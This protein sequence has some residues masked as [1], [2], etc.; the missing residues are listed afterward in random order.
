MANK[1]GS[2]MESN[3]KIALIKAIE[4]EREGKRFYLESAQKAVSLL[5]RR[6]FEELASAEDLHIETIQKICNGLQEDKLF[7]QWVTAVNPSGKLEKVFE[8][9]LVEKA[10]A[11][12]DDIKALHF[13][14]E[15]EEKS[16]R[17]Y[18]SLAGDAESPFE[19]RFYLA[20]SYEE[21]GHSLKIMDSIEYLN[22]PTSW[23][24]LRDG[25]NL[26]G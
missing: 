22:D 23:I 20:L 13:G 15:L 14:L 6:V 7:R 19:R 8:E 5:A 3:K 24:Y 9:S 10:K 25:R 18:E 4:M 17:Y 16:V 1:G 21:R 2:R 12:E 26:E 11:S